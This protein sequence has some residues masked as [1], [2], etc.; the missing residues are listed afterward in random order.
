MAVEGGNRGL[1]G[2]VAWTG[3]LI[4]LEDAWFGIGIGYLQ[5]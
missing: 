2:G 4:R 3:L 5:L 1:H